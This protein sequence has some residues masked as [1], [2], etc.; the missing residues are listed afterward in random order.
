MTPQIY[1]LDPKYQ[2]IRHNREVWAAVKH[3]VWGV[4]WEAEGAHM[5]AI[6]P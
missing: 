6:D 3:P 2:G 5:G 1:N 4:V